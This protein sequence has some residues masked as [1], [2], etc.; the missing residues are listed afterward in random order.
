MVRVQS[1]LW[2][3]YIPILMVRVQSGLWSEYIPSS[4]GSRYAALLIMAGEVIRI[5][6][7]VQSGLGSEFSP[8]Y[9]QSTVRNPDYGFVA[10]RTT[11]RVQSGL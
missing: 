9:G 3:E 2:S 7:R 11:V 5:M 4:A 1:Y 10:A 8:D 6:V